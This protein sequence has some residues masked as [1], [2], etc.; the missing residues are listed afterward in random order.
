[1]ARDLRPHLLD[2]VERMSKEYP[3]FMDWA[4]DVLKN[5][6]SG[7]TVLLPVIAQ[8]LLDAY[9]K[10]L[11]QEPVLRK[12]FKDEEVDEPAPADRVMRRTRPAVEQPAV[13]QRVRRTRPV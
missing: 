1:M 11:A 2:D 10:G 4:R 8:G 3:E 6:E 13:T 7:K 5:W 12:P 9:T